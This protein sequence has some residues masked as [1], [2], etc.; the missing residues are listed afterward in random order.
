[1]MMNSE[2]NKGN[3]TGNLNPHELKSVKHS[4]V[5]QSAIFEQNFNNGSSFN[6]FSDS[7][8][9]PTKPVISI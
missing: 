4:A 9:T 1:M 2:K 3:L 6:S 7:K 5:S 8:P